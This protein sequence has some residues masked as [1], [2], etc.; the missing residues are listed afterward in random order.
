MVQWSCAY[1]PRHPLPN[2]NCPV[3]GCYRVLDAKVVGLGQTGEDVQAVHR[4]RT[5][6]AGVSGISG[7]AGT[8]EGQGRGRGEDGWGIFRKN[9]FLQLGMCRFTGSYAGGVR[10]AGRRRYI[11]SILLRKIS[12]IVV[13]VDLSL[14]CEECYR[15]TW[16]W[17]SSRRQSQ[18]RI[19]TRKSRVDNRLWRPRLQVIAETALLC[20]S[21]MNRTSPWR[22]S[23]SMAQTL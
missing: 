2:A 12:E 3:Y 19:S 11:I 9:Y 20:S 16:I 7:R 22:R 10:G 23:T 13:T 8:G 4:G 17:G 1:Q 15:L 14:T 21:A 18:P 5:K 6:D